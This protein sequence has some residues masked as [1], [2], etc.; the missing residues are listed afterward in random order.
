MK[1]ETV[2]VIFKRMGSGLYSAF[3]YLVQVIITAL[4]GYMLCLFFGV[5]GVQ[6]LVL[7]IFRATSFGAGA[8]PSSIDM[9]LM[10][11]FPALFLT[12]ILFVVTLLLLR[13]LW[14]FLSK[15]FHRLRKKDEE[16]EEK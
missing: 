2:K 3:L 12:G 14:R 16:R 4:V 9:L 11:G 7:E 13:G 8:T 5:Y 15:I 1:K 10:V 6:K